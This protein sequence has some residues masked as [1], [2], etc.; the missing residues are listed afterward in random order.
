MTA[1]NQFKALRKSENLTKLRNAHTVVESDKCDRRFVRFYLFDF[2]VKM[3]KIVI[4]SRF[5]THF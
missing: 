3:K 5:Y 1:H 2:Y 4:K